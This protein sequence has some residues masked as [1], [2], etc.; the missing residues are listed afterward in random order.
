ML[1]DAKK[2]ALLAPKVDVNTAMFGEH[3]PLHVAVSSGFVDVVKVLLG[4][5]ADPNAKFG[6][7]QAPLHKAAYLGDAQST[8]ALIEAGADVR[9]PG[10][11]LLQPLHYAALGYTGARYNKED[12]SFSFGGRD[13]TKEVSTVM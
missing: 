4:N 2:V 1:A 13:V 11:M 9:V 8:A 5:G 6:D 12:M 3:S 10:P 7:N